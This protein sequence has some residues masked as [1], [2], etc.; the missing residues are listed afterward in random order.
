[1]E[2]EGV[3]VAYLHEDIAHLVEVGAIGHRGHKVEADDFLLGMVDKAFVGELAV[4]DDDSAAVEGAHEGVENTDFLYVAFV[5]TTFDVV[6]HFEGFHEKD[7]DTAGEVLKRALQGHADGQT[8]GTQESDEGGGFD[9]HHIHGHDD[10]HGFE[11]HIDQ[12]AQKRF[13]R[14]FGIASLKTAKD[15]FFE[16]LGQFHAYPENED[17]NEEFGDE[18][19]RHLGEGFHAVAEDGVFAS[20]HTFQVVEIHVPEAVGDGLCDTVGGGEGLGKFVNRLVGDLG[21]FE[22]SSCQ[23]RGGFVVE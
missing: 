2:D 16:H 20:H 1:M 4:G 15:D 5:G 22:G 12:R 13:E 11:K 8:H 21:I 9:A 7:D 6:A 19:D 10:D 14:G 23:Q 17:G 3:F 18:T